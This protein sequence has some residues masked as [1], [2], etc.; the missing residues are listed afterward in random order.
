MLGLTVSA[1]M[2]QQS[3]PRSVQSFVG[4][5]SA[6]VDRSG[7]AAAGAPAAGSEDI[8][9]IGAAVAELGSLVAGLDLDT[10]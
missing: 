7:T 5:E 6:L 1:Q 8:L 4:L 9:Y 2:M 10:L 3:E